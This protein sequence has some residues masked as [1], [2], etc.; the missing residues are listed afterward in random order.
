MRSM[1]CCAGCGRRN[2]RRRA[3]GRHEAPALESEP[4]SDRLCDWPAP[5]MATARGAACHLAGL[6]SGP[7]AR[8]RGAGGTVCGR[9]DLAVDRGDLAADAVRLG[10]RVTPGHRDRR[11]DRLIRAGAGLPRAYTRVPA[12]AAGL[13]GHSGRDPVPRPLQRDVRLGDRVRRYLA[14][15]AVEHLRLRLPAGPPAGGLGGARLWP[16]RV[17]AQDRLSGRAARYPLRRARK[18]GNLSHPRCRHR[19]AG[20]LARARARHLLRATQLPQRRS[21]RRPDHAGSDRVH[22]EPRPVSDR[23]PPAEMASSQRIKLGGKFMLNYRAL[24]LIGALTIAALS[25]AAAQSKK[26]AVG[27]ASASDFLPAFIGKEKGCFEKRGLDVTLT[28]IPIVGNIP[29]ALVAGSLQIGMSTA[30]VLLQAADGG[31]DLNVVAGATRMLKDNPT[32]SLVVRN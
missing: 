22:G 28:R 6:L 21:L 16:R 17:P 10:V 8:V 2:Q 30:T 26:V 31:I 29:P 18:L 20:L 23:E 15:S 7:V 12:A 13:G 14:G 19:D 1:R 27:Y 3:G 9:L 5:G 24:A 11:G 32:I 25:P 4:A